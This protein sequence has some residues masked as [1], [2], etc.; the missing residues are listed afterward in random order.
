M[1]RKSNWAVIGCGA[2]SKSYCDAIMVAE[3]TAKAE[4]YNVKNIYTDYKEI[5]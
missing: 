5:A 2:V 4:N 1:S 3:E